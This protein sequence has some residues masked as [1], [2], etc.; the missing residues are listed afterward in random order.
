MRK[1]IAVAASMGGK[2]FLSISPVPVHWHVVQAAGFAAIMNG[3]CW[4][5]VAIYRRAVFRT[6]F[7]NGLTSD[8]F[9]RQMNFNVMHR[10]L[11]IIRLGWIRVR[12]EC[13]AYIQSLDDVDCDL[14][15]FV[16][17]NDYVVPV[18]YDLLIVIKKSPS[19]L[20]ERV[21][22]HFVIVLYLL[23]RVLYANAFDFFLRDLLRLKRRLPDFHTWCMANLN[24]VLVC[25]HIEYQHKE[26]APL[27]EHLSDRGAHAVHS[28]ICSL[29]AVRDSNVHASTYDGLFKPCRSNGCSLDAASERRWRWDASLPPIL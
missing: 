3:V 12:A 23:D 17:W 11:N 19:E 13:L 14:A 18:I 2:V 27:T 4:K 28:L 25:L 10:H 20:Y 6:K 7:K 21:L 24:R 22:A 29:P 16:T 1:A 26:L 8:H 9:S 5:F 15:A